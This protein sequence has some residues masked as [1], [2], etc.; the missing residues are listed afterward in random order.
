MLDFL[1][2]LGLEVS[3]SFASYSLSQVKYA[4]N[5]LLRSSITD[6]ATAPTLVNPN[7]CL[8]LFDGIPLEDTSLYCHLVGSL[9][10]LTITRPD[11]AYVVHIV[12]QFMAALRTIH[13]TAVLCILRYV[14]ELLWLRWL[15]AD[16]GVPQSSAT[17]LHCD[18]RSAIQIAHNDVFQERTKHIENDCH[19]VCHHLLSETLMLR[20]ISTA[21]QPTDILTK[22][23][24]PEIEDGNVEEIDHDEKEKD[25]E[26]DGQEI[27]VQEQEVEEEIL[28]EEEEELE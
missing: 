6:F 19:F 28:I 11:I 9:I 1:H 2:F 20:S 17:I 4:L 13:F 25:F 26:V 22:A 12:S 10:Y 24:P 21:E 16:I 15:L 27:E 23:L 5:L 8:T 3:L 14:K 18:N 7:V